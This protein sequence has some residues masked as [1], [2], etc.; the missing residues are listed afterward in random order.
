MFAGISQQAGM[1]EERRG[2]VCTEKLIQNQFI[3]RIHELVTCFTEIH[4]FLR[5]PEC[6]LKVDLFYCY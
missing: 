6:H 2:T 4:V 1:R 3:Q 5:N